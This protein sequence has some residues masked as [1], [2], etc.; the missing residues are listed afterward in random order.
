MLTPEQR[1]AIRLEVHAV[2][3]A[4]IEAIIA[5]ISDG[6][7]EWKKERKETDDRTDRD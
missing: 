7:E 5:G 4:L 2:A 3:C 6:I 1:E